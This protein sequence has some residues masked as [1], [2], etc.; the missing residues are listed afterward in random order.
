MNSLSYYLQYDNLIVFDQEDLFL[1]DKL[2]SCLK[3]V[4]FQEDIHY[5]ILNDKEQKEWSEYHGNHKF[6]QI[7]IHGIY[8]GNDVMFLSYIEDKILQKIL[9]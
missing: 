1:K 8:L 9:K 7:Y 4:S 5:F 6:P 2:F 3:N